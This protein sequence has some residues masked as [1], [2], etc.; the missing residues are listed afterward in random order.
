MA[1]DDYKHLDNGEWE[2][3]HSAHRYPG[4]VGYAWAARTLSGR[5]VKG[6]TQRA[7]GREAAEA[8]ARRA[9]ELKH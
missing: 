3:D 6:V 1:N 8:K 4:R 7:E 5:L 9:A 2:C